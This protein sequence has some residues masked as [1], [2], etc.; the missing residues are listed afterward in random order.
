MARGLRDDADTAAEEFFELFFIFLDV[1]LFGF[2]N[3]CEHPFVLLAAR[4]P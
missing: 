4:P 2:L 1:F 3:A